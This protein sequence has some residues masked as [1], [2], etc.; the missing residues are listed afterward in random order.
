MAQ[1]KKG[2]AL[3][4][5]RKALDEI[6]ELKPLSAN[7]PQFK[8]WRRDTRVAITNTF[9]SDSEHI[10][11]FGAARFFHFPCT[12]LLQGSKRPIRKAWNRQRRYSSP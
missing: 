11:D 4:R 1:T 5:L 7:S 3:E 2:K 9:G 12:H 10:A 6:A 8:K